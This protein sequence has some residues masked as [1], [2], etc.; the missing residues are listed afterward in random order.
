MVTEMKRLFGD[1]ALYGM[2][3]ILARLLNF[4]LTPLLTVYLTKSEYGINALLYVS[5]A[6]LMVILT[7]GFETA[8]FRMANRADRDARTVFSTAMWSIL[9]TTTIFL[10]LAHVFYGGVSG[11]LNLAD[12]PEY[13]LMMAWIV[14]MDVVATVPFA[15]L[16]SEKRAIRFVTVKTLQIAFNLALN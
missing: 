10:V 6:F 15:Q 16:R 8:Y 5:V 13:V 2:S 7:Y 14:A 4:L 12:R 11:A 3:S 9:S 1:A